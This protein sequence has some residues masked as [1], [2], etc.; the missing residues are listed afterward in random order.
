MWKYTIFILIGILIFL[1]LN[2]YNT[3]SVGVPWA[4]PISKEF[5]VF[6]IDTIM[7]PNTQNINIP[8]S[9]SRFIP[10]RIYNRLD[11]PPLDI[12]GE[13][14]FVTDI[15]PQEGVLLR[16]QPQLLQAIQ[17]EIE[18]PEREERER[19][20]NEGETGIRETDVE[21][22]SREER[23]RDNNEGETGIRETNAERDERQRAR[24]RER[25]RERDRQERER[26]ERERQAFI[27]RWETNTENLF[28][29]G[30]IIAYVQDGEV[31]IRQLN[32][33]GL[34]T[35]ELGVI[36][37]L[38]TITLNELHERTNPGGVLYYVIRLTQVETHV[39]HNIITGG[40]TIQFTG[41]ILGIGGDTAINPNIQELNG[42]NRFLPLIPNDDQ[43]NIITQRLRALNPYLRNHY[44]T[45]F[46]EIITAFIGFPLG[47]NTQ[48]GNILNVLYLLIYF[49]YR[50]N[51]IPNV[52][53]EQA[54]EAEPP[55]NVQITGTTA[56][57]GAN[58]VVRGRS[59]GAPRRSRTRVRTRC[60]AEGIPPTTQ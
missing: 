21:R 27:A 53:Q 6:D 26:E 29:N 43:A 58:L 54:E 35:D 33:Q 1:L 48:A 20:N 22:Y 30:Y 4:I 56:G 49:G 60:A 8:V 9:E 25:E 55:V 14:F 36:N 13:F 45:Q 52:E 57:G 37:G 17:Y 18:R 42:M 41:T 24:E 44:L 23:E 46:R 51:D 2:R 38:E 39:W 12:R 11:L 59:T 3:F 16:D 40:T 32:D 47:G 34:N 7:L 5:G 19:D 50:G 10:N 15:Q 31:I 28:M